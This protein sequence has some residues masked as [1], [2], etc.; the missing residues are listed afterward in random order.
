MRPKPAGQEDRRNGKSI[1]LAS[2]QGGERFGPTSGFDSLADL[3]NYS[4]PIAVIFVRREDDIGGVLATPQ[5]VWSRAF[6]YGNEQGVKLMFVLGEEGLGEGIN[7]PDLEGIFLGTAPLDG[8]YGNKYAFYWNRNTNV[9]GRIKAKNFAYGTRA[10]ADA[11]DPQTNDDIFLAPRGNAVNAMA[12]SQSYTPSSNN[13]FGCYV[14]VRNGTGYRINWEL[15]PL[16]IQDGEDNDDAED[17]LRSTTIRRHKIAGDWGAGTS[18]DKNIRNG[19]RGVGREYGTRMG[20]RFYNG[21]SLAPGGPDGHKVKQVVSVGAGAT[22]VI[23]G[24]VIEEQRYWAGDDTEANHVDDINNATIRMREEADDLLQVGQI[25]MIARTVWVVKSRSEDIW[26]KGIVGPFDPRGT[27]TIELNAWKS[28]P[29]AEKVRRSVLLATRSSPAAS[30][31][32]TKARANTNT[33]R[34]IRG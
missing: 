33:P 30:S 23:G 29:M 28:L 13:T 27:Q 21:Q 18:L 16:A 8:L 15:V 5:L 3:A 24:N 32:T 26:G 25:V 20:L 2:R 17:R 22:F 14:A 34:Q 31:L 4:E 12:F 9:N 1:C 10:T 11:G 6:S 7:R 19:Q